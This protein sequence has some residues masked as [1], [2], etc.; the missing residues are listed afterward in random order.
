MIGL[1]EVCLT[2]EPDLS[3]LNQTLLPAGQAVTLGHNFP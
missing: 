2:L 3:T 1:L